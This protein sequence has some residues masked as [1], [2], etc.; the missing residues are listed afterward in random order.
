MASFCPCFAYWLLLCHSGW[1]V[2]DYSSY[3]PGWSI[4]NNPS[5]Q[6]FHPLC[7]A[8]MHC[9]IPCPLQPKSL[10]QLIFDTF[11]PHTVATKSLLLQHHLQLNAEAKAAQEIHNHI[12]IPPEVVRLLQLNALTQPPESYA[13]TAPMLLPPPL[14][15]GTKMSIE[16]FCSQFS[17]SVEIL[18]CLCAN[19]YSGS[20]IIQHI[21]IGKLW[22]IAFK[23]GE[24]TELKE[25]VHVWATS[26]DSI[27]QTS[28]LS[29][30]HVLMC[31]HM[32]SSISY[33]HTLC[34]QLFTFYLC[35]HNTVTF[36]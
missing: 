17:L 33:S 26:D 28:S 19:G 9:Q 34:S 14:T 15:P 22:T 1:A 18:E 20:H 7:T 4:S 11:N 35:M 32:L 12:N 16:D 13:N 29:C 23:P 5:D 3:R 25:A 8:H 30:S 24:I 31:S 6:L 10:N 21:E 27:W 2:L 36:K